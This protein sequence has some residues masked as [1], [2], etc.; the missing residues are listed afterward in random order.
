MH[1]YQRLMVALTHSRTDENLIR[2]AASF[3]RLGSTREV[4]FVQ[5]LPSSAT[6]RSASDRYRI[7]AQLQEEVQSH[8]VDLPLTVQLSY[9]LISGP[10]MDSL[11]TAV[12]EK[13]VDLLLVGPELDSSSSRALTRRLAM[14]APCSVLLLPEEPTGKMQRILVAIDFS[15]PAADSVAVA[16]SL[17]RLRGIAEVVALH[18]YFNET[19]V[20]YEGYDQ[21]L[22]GEEED[23]YRKFISPIDCQGV[24]ILPIFQ[25]GANVA[26]AIKRAAN[27][28]SA[29][30]IIM[31]TRGRS[32][33]ASILLGSVTEELIE[34]THVPLLAVKH[35]GHSMRLIDALLDKQFQK[36]DGLRTD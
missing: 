32:Q 23:A 24:K 5:I 6:P 26:N 29:D 15:K 30:L 20:N 36:R 11:L 28:Q 27:E 21:V 31:S 7:L 13:H 8:F 25:E 18:I 33:S 34:T 19:L 22:R 1:R 16:A 9:E 12:T 3:I 17:A 4:C 10:L 2:H 35:F 14:K